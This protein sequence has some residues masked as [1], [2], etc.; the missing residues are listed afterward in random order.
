MRFQTGSG[1]KVRALVHKTANLRS[2]DP[3]AIVL[4]IA[5]RLGGEAYDA[6]ESDRLCADRD[7]FLPESESR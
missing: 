1:R 2:R 3:S 4:L 5:I 6:R 7:V